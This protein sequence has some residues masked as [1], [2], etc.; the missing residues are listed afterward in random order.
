M[1]WS[2]LPLLPLGLVA[3]LLSGLLGIGGGLIFS[4]LLLLAGLD[5]H[6]AL[7]TSTLA[8]VPTTMAGSW[9]HIR[10]QSLPWKAVLAI[11]SSAAV[12]GALF[13]R[14]GGVLEGW[15]LMAFQATMYLLLTLTITPRSRLPAAQDQSHPPLAG[16]TAIGCVAGAASGLVGVGGGLIMVPLMVRALRLRIH[17]AIRYSTLAVLASALTASAAFVSDGRAN[18]L[19]GLLLGATAGITARWAAARMYR[20]SEDRLAWL[21]RVVTLVLTLDSGRRA[22]TLALQ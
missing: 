9:A 14:L 15:L 18:L 6:H 8:I 13:S 19:A 20:V 7:A 1:T 2:L 22:V 11:A 10:Q 12:A 17:E 3:G 21:I 4:P 5:P 16:L